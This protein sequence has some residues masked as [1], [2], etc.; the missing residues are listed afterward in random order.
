[1]MNPHAWAAI[2]LDALLHNLGVARSAAPGSALCVVVKANAYGHGVAPVVS[3]LRSAM[4]AGDQFAVVTLAEAVAVQQIAAGM[5]V[6]AMRGALDQQEMDRLLAQDIE[7]VIHS[8]WQLTLLEQSLASG[9]R[10]SLPSL[11][12]WLK[13]NTGMNRLGLPASDV[14]GVWNAV[15]TLA[16]QYGLTCS[17]VLMSHLATSDDLQGPLTAQQHQSLESVR[18]TLTLTPSDQVSLAASAGIL[19]WPQTHYSVVRPGI[20]LYGASPLLGRTGKQDGLRPV[21]NL[22]SR[23]IAVNRVSAGASIGYGAT[24]R[25]DRDMMVGIVGIGYGDGYP[26]HAPTGTPVL[27]RTGDG[28]VHECSL[29]GR[30]SMDMLAVDLTGVDAQVG[31]EVL[32]WGQAWDRRLPAERIAELCHTITYELFCQIT[33]RVTFHYQ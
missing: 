19:G 16:S 1:M 32:L 31:D 29:V 20:M 30:V 13:V 11:R 9:V 27:L 12:V 3:S 10:P 24:Y 33:T 14:A 22:K 21:M 4:K 18:Q 28:Q 7:F 2:D 8:P 17:R 25:S 6:L 26:R 15:A 23:L 5:P